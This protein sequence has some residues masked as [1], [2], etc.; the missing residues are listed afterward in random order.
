MITRSPAATASQTTGHHLADGGLPVGN[1]RTPT[2]LNSV[3]PGTHV[4]TASHEISLA[5]G[6]EPCASND[7]RV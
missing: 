2:V 1:S 4:Q 7:C 3:N 5:S 6:R